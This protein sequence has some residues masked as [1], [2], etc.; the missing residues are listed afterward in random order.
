MVSVRLG[1]SADW[2]KCPRDWLY[3]VLLLNVLL[4]NVIALKFT[5]AVVRAV[6]NSLNDGADI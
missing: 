1:V 4:L 6:F 2:V 5:V 3:R